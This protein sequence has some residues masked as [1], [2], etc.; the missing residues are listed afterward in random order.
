LCT[1]LEQTW[2]HKFLINKDDERA[3][4]LYDLNPEGVRLVDFNPT[5]ENIG[6]HILNT[7]APKLLVGTNTQ[8]I[9]ISV[10]ETR[11]CSAT[12]EL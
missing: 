8:L 12:V 1:W 6:A 9:K 5:A 10:E 11:K 4:A 3:P 2:D 7:V